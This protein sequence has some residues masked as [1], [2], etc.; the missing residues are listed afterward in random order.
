MIEPTMP[1]NSGQYGARKRTQDALM[2]KIRFQDGC[3]IWTS[4]LSVFETPIVYLGGDASSAAG[5][6]WEA[7]RGAW[8]PQTARPCVHNK[9]CVRPECWERN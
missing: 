9:L 2:R 7:W 6:V 3:W 1:Y 5:A 8:M 4:T